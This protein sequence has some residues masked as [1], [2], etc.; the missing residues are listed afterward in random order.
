MIGASNLRS[1][2]QL[3]QLQDEITVLSSL[4]HPNI[5]RLREMHFSR[6]TATFH[7][8]MDLASGGSLADHTAT[9]VRGGD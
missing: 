6:A 8:V 2:G 3:E 1:I 9:L 5:V 7:F 4:H